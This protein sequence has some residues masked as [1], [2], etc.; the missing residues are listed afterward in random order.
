M[1]RPE[2]GTLGQWLGGAVAAI[3]AVTL[4]WLLYNRP[5]QLAYT[6]TSLTLSAD[7]ARSLL[8]NLTIR[9]GSQDVNLVTVNTIE[10]WLNPGWLTTRRYLEKATV[11]I[12]WEHDVKHYVKV[13]SEAPSSA[14]G[15]SCL[16]HKSGA[17]CDL[18]RISKADR[19]YR[20]TLAT[21]QDRP[22]MVQL[23]AKDTELIRAEALK[24]GAT[25]LDA[26]VGV[27]GV[28]LVT[29]FFGLR[30]NAVV[31]MIKKQAKEPPGESKSPGATAGQP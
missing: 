22:P 29:L 1:R 12:D 8:P 11:A 13:K 18:E 3:L 23:V 24:A 25:F 17:T 27:L 28:F 6:L 5:T 9:I 31:S 16:E 19:P 4:G 14:H 10:F 2:L 26:S 20:I 21:D 7:P 30:L 15:V